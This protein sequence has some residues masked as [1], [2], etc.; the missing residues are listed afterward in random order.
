[1]DVS[2]IIVNYHTPD[3]VI[4]CI[5]SVFDHTQGITYEIIVVDN[6]SKDDSVNKIRS[7]FRDKVQVIA[8]EDNLGFGKGNNLGVSYATGEYVL[9]LNPDTY[10]INNA[11]KVLF[12]YISTHKKIGIIGGNLYFPDL[13]PA[14]SFCLEFDTPTAE[15]RNA[16]WVSIISKKILNKLNISHGRPFEKNFNY[17]D[18]IMKVGYIFGADMMLRR[19]VFL[20]EGGFDPDFFMYAE[21]EELSWRITKSGY[22]IVNDPNAKIVHLEGAST[23]EHIDGFNKRQFQM[24]M[25]GKLV[26]Y[27]KC[28]GTTG[29]NAF[30]RYRVLYYERLIKLAKL[31]GKDPKNTMAYKMLECLNETDKEMFDQN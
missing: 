22:I 19:D 7:F 8:S 20:A 24:R 17:S 27:K 4:D 6:A 18:K 30:Y 3:L 28:F 10:L 23:S 12:D 25:N 29:A 11:V 31:Q 9:L 16:S 13:S 2:I 21:E 26:Y 14:P 1:M 5:N 15:K